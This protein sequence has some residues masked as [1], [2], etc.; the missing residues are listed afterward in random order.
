MEAEAPI[1]A[2]EPLACAP[3][4]FRRW[5]A[6]QADAEEARNRVVDAMAPPIAMA[7][8]LDARAPD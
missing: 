3:A 5:A 8:L 1:P 6:R 4:P 2:I 7:I